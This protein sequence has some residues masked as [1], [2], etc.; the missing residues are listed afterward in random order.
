MVK[1][2]KWSNYQGGQHNRELTYASSN[3]LCM[4][5]LLTYA[6]DEYMKSGQHY[7]SDQ[8]TDQC[9]ESGQLSAMND[10]LKKIL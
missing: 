6:G 10:P 1:I 9:T 2:R 8:D 7:A 4:L 3:K 5:G